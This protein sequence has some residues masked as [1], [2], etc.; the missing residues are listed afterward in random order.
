[1]PGGYLRACW[2]GGVYLL[3]TLGLL[4]V[5]IAAVALNLRLAER[6]PPFYHRSVCRIIGLDVERRGEMSPRRPT[7]FICNHTSYLDISVL[8]GLIAGSFV[9]K[10]EVAD[11]PLYGR[12][13]KLQ[14]S[15]FVTRRRD[16]A[17]GARDELAGRLAA[18]DNLILFPEG[19]SNDGNRVLPFK[20]ALFSVAERRPGDAPLTVQPV[21]VAY[22]RLNGQPMRRQLRPLVAWYGDMELVGHLWRLLGLGTLTVEVTFH[23]PV[24][25]EAFGTRKAL[26]AHCHETIAAAVSAAIHGTRPAGAGDTKPGGAGVEG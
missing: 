16:K 24:T 13:A 7:L 11:W 23:P 15:V 5:Q 6:I 18:G 17:G 12:L 19:T 9:A 22:S 25:I 3:W 14:R 8:G 2:R 1:M 20:S 4:P 21:S 10:R 26:A